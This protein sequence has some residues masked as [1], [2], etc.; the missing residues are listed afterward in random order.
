MKWKFIKEY[1][2]GF[3]LWQNKIGFKECFTTNVN[4]NNLK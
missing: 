3:V 4:P 1:P 2:H